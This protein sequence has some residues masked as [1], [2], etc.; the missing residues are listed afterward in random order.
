MELGAALGW[1]HGGRRVLVVVL[2]TGAGHAGKTRTAAAS[3]VD[4]EPHELVQRYLPPDQT[5]AVRIRRKA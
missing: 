5:F 1:T 4:Q 3:L 2:A